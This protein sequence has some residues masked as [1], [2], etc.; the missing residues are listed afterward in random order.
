VSAEALRYPNTSDH[1]VGISTDGYHC[2]DMIGL[3]GTVSASV[4]K[5][6]A[7][8]LEAMARWLPQFKTKHLKH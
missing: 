8:G 7:L 4:G 3:E 6:Q 2:S 5:V 1:T